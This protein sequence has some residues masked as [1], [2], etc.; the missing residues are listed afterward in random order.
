M[1][2]KAYAAPYSANYLNRHDVPRIH[3]NDVNSDEIDVGGGVRLLPAAIERANEMAL[4]WLD[5]G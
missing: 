3:R 2:A 5:G 1:R 4:V